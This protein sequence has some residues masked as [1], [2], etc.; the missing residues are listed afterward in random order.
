VARASIPIAEPAATAATSIAARTRPTIPGRR[1]AASAEP[2]SVATRAG[3]RVTADRTAADIADDGRLAADARMAAAKLLP[4]RIAFLGFGLIGGS[5]AAALRAT[6]SSS[7]LV[8]WTPSGGGSAAGLRLGFIDEA[9]K[10]AAEAVDGA[11]LIVL[12]GPPLAVLESLDVLGGPL[13]GGLRDDVVITDVASTKAEIVERADHRGV[14]FV[15]GHPMAGRESSGAD[16]A[17]ADLFVGRPWVIVPGP[18]ASAADVA[19]VEALATAAGARPTPMTAAD[20][21]A[22][23]SA[24]SHLPL[25]LAAALVEAVAGAGPSNPTWAAARA[26]AAGGWA[27]MTRLARGDPEMGAGILATNAANVTVRLRAIRRELDTWIEALDGASG[28]VDPTPPD[29]RALAARLRAARDLLE[30][31]DAPA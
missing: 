30:A 2:P 27:D 4:D 31:P 6:G 13:R 29:H 21:D 7:R 24:I 22:A 3:E 17:T 14:R 12:A 5:I 8:A 25:V 10:T 19:V 11:G 16:A 15:G 9:A 1:A 18:A 26:L 20:H 23:V 28:S